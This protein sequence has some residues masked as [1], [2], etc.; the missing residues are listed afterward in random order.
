MPPQAGQCSAA[1]KNKSLQ[2]T[3]RI[4]R[5]IASRKKAPPQKQD[6]KVQKKL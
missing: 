4:S 3:F 2:N 1:L 5:G 6:K